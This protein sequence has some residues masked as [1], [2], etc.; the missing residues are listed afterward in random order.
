MAF[1]RHCIVQGEG[2]ELV[3]GRI[4]EFVTAVD[5]ALGRRRP[6]R[7]VPSRRSEQLRAIG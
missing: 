2:S 5:D 6:P 4:A 7:N 3:H 1:A